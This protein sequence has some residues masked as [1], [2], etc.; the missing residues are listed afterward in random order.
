MQRLNSL[1]NKVIVLGLFGAA[2]YSAYENQ[3]TLM[4]LVS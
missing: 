2:L 4:A 1:F 3:A